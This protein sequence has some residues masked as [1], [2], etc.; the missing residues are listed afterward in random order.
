M[1][2]TT[3]I[4]IFLDTR[5]CVSKSIKHIKWSTACFSSN[6]AILANKPS[7]TRF[8]NIEVLCSKRNLVLFIMLDVLFITPISKFVFTKPW[9]MNVILLFLPPPPLSPFC[10]LLFIH[11]MLFGY[12]WEQKHKCL[13]TIN[14]FVSETESETTVQQ[15]SFCWPHAKM[16][17]LKQ[18]IFHSKLKQCNMYKH[19]M[20][21][22]R[23]WVIL[24]ML[25]GL[26]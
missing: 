12:S 24:H 2:I 7:G 23:V 18:A 15:N 13:T 21:L 9:K 25:I 22:F 11:E 14:A 6:V 10:S 5:L 16:C 3:H 1:K 8:I 26:F 20:F 17:F 19:F 4:F